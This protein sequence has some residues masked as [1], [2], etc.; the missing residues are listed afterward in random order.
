MCSLVVYKGHGRHLAGS[1]QS[2]SVSV[3]LASFRCYR[4]HS[5][6]VVKV[7]PLHLGIETVSPW[8]PSNAGIVECLKPGKTTQL[9][10]F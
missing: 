2:A 4:W 7:L 6:T 3:F 5:E 9:V 10:M 1:L 8:R